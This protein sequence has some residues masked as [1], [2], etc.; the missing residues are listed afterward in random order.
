MLL[1]GTR[2]CE[3]CCGRSH[4]NTLVQ[5]SRHFYRYWWVHNDCYGRDRL[6]RSQA[7]IKMMIQLAQNSFPLWCSRFFVPRKLVL[8]ISQDLVERDRERDS[9]HDWLFVL[10]ISAYEH[11]M[12]TV[13]DPFICKSIKLYYHSSVPFLLSV[14]ALVGTP[15]PTN[16]LFCFQVNI[17]RFSSERNLFT[18]DISRFS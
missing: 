5:K 8:R 9:F 10:F 13:C 15:Y 4:L 17:S 14:D 1:S 12:H 18:V 6:W 16:V 3:R 11:V 2:Q 7:E